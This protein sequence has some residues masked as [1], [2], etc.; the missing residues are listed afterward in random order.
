MSSNPTNPNTVASTVINGDGRGTAL[1]TMADSPAGTLLSGFTIRNNP[2]Y[3][4]YTP[5][6]GVVAGSATIT[7][8]TITGAGEGAIGYGDG[9]IE[10][11]TI[12]DNH[13]YDGGGICH[14][15]GA[16]TDCTITGNIS[17]DGGGALSDCT[18]IIAGCT[19]NDNWAW[20][21]GGALSECS[22]TVT[23]CTISGNHA[24][25]GGAAFECADL[26][27]CTI[28][29]NW[30]D[31]GGGLYGC[32]GTISNCTITRNS[33]TYGG[34][35]FGCTGGVQNSMILGNSAEQG[36]GIYN[37][38]TY[39]GGVTI[40]DSL[41]IGN[42]ATTQGGAIFCD[43]PATLVNCTVNSN[44]GGSSGA[45]YVNQ[46]SSLALS[47]CILW[48]NPDPQVYAG[49]LGAVTVSYSDVSGG[50]EGIFLSQ[51]ATLNWVVDRENND[52]NL[53]ADP[54]FRRAPSAGNDGV[55][56]TPDD[57]Y[58]DLH[59]GPDSPCIDA[60]DPSFTLATGQVDAYGSPRLFGTR[61]DIGAAERLPSLIP[62]GFVVYGTNRPYRRDLP[63]ELRNE[64]SCR[65][66]GTT[67]EL[68][69]T[70]PVQSLIGSGGHLISLRLAGTE[71]D[72]ASQYP[73]SFT[74]TWE[75]DGAT[76]K[77]VE[78]RLLT[79]SGWYQVKPGPDLPVENDTWQFF[80]VAGDADG[81]GAVNLADLKIVTDAWGTTPAS[82]NW[83]PDGDLD[84]DN[85]VNLAD[86]KMIVD[87]W[88]RSYF[89]AEEQSQMLLRAAL[90]DDGTVSESTN[91]DNMDVYQ[92]LE[93]VGLLDIWLDYLSSQTQPAQ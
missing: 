1:V 25:Y 71:I 59:L 6:I 63:E 26:T 52:T 34:G 2:D 30:A 17:E 44:D 87:N 41:I 86:L 61:V 11:C 27:G 82:P 43:A 84:G 55:W 40:Q 70:E 24:V 28:T 10:N 62:D 72:Y 50:Q 90:S 23:G 20:G 77:I 35:A 19:I 54:A 12:R 3:G 83:N 57:D 46:E 91:A 85:A 45:V 5:S 32:T 18:G 56:G 93:S 48:G 78:N 88:N 79:L 53:A 38:G 4:A 39:Q 15:D 68:Y 80:V 69:F 58:G 31:W 76:L 47:D 8:C 60:G 42:S 65:A 66:K 67:I 64:Y 7:N 9:S 36:G 29:G 14:Y 92:A 16:V 37:G 13:G 73:S 75:D 74:F 51:G 49:Y 21:W 89:E 81:D 33:A 22:G